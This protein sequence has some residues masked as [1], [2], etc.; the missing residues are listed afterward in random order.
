MHERLQGKL[1]AL[2]VDAGLEAPVRGDPTQPAAPILEP[3]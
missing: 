3:V 2:E 1:G